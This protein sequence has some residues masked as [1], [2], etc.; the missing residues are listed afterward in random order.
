LNKLQSLLII[1]I[2]AVG[3]IFVSSTSDQFVD[4]GSRKKFHFT[5]TI[6]SSQDPAQGT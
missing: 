6:T 4:A 2:F 5:Q 1:G 3:I